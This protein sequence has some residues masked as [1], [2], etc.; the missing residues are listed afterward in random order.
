MTTPTREERVLELE[1]RRLRTVAESILII[2]LV[3]PSGASLPEWKP[4]AHLDLV[5][6]NGMIRQYSLC[7]DSTER[8]MYSVAVLRDPSS[9]GGSNHIHDTFV[10]GMSVE[11]KGPRNH[12]PLVESPRY[13]F[14]AGGIGIT[15]IVPMIASAVAAG[16]DWS[17]HYGGRSRGSM[18]FLD[19]LDAL[20]R[21]RVTIHP[22]DESGILDLESLLRE[23]DPDTVVY[24]CGPYSLLQAIEDRTAG[25]PSGSVHME[26]FSPK[27]IDVPAVAD[28]FEIELSESNK[29]LVVEPDKS[30]LQTLEEAGIEVYSSCQDGTCGTC[31]TPVLSGIVDHRDSILGPEEQA[32]H[33]CMY[34][35]VSRAACS[36][37]VLEI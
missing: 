24:T 6:S 14:V 19:E 36:R 5:L 31:E 20:G 29:V 11:V 21:D 16:A 22:E 26:R 3:D 32:A 17:L 13:L 7:G 2:D 37:L 25:W 30:V 12:F 9:R 28:S 8:G 35:C 10:E 15:P 23:H 27:V 33:D 1:V 18:A 34:V 4:G